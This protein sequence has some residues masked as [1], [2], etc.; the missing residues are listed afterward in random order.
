MK[1]T[2]ILPLDKCLHVIAGVII[3]AALLH[4][5]GAN[6]ALASTIAI[7]SLKEIYDYLFPEKHTCDIL[8]AVAT[9]VGAV[10][11]YSCTL[12]F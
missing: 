7:G 6:Y 10:L 5:L 9:W 3:F 11:A 2:N 1:L 8:D 12:V 4:V